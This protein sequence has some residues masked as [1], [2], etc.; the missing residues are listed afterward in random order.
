MSIYVNTGSVSE[1][2]IGSGEITEII[3]DWTTKEDGE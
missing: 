1:R 3:I 2:N